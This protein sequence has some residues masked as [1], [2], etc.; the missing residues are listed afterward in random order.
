[1]VAENGRVARTLL[2]RTLFPITSPDCFLPSLRSS[3]KRSLIISTNITGRDYNFPRPIESFLQRRS[4]WSIHR[5]LPLVRHRFTDGRKT[6]LTSGLAGFSKKTVLSSIRWT[7]KR[8][9]RFLNAVARHALRKHHSLIKLWGVIRGT[10]FTRC[11]I[12]IASARFIPRGVSF[13]IHRFK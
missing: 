9:L 5:T 6:R 11:V 4:G 12:G 10:R 8:I 3:L 1:M 13:L 7:E 2:L